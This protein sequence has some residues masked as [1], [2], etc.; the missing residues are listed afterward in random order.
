M[1]LQ[2]MCIYVHQQRMVIYLHIVC[3]DSLDPS[4]WV[5]ACTRVVCVLLQCG[6]DTS[7][8]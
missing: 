5:R 6:K 8:G 1:P 2:L 4:R 7:Q 3:A